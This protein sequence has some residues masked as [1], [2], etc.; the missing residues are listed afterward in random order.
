[1]NSALRAT[2]LRGDPVSERPTGDDMR[3]YAVECVVDRV[4][5]TIDR[6]KDLN[7]RREG[8]E[9]HK[10]AL[11]RDGPV[12]PAPRLEPLGFPF[13]RPPGYG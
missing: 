3:K 1:M 7:R 9:G 5:P 4:G 6:K 8:D 12:D 2:G 10:D 11:P 13:P